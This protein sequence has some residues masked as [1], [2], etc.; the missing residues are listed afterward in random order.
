MDEGKNNW[1]QYG[2]NPHI[3][4]NLLTKEFRC[5]TC[6]QLLGDNAGGAGSHCKG[7]H[8]IRIDGNRIREEPVCETETIQPKV[9]S[10]PATQHQLVPRPQVVRSYE[11]EERRQKL[12]DELQNNPPLEKDDSVK[13][14]E[15]M[16]KKR[17]L[18]NKYQQLEINR[19]PESILRQYRIE[20]G[21]EDDY[22][23]KKKE[24]KRKQEEKEFVERLRRIYLIKMFVS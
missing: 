5:V 8:G 2:E 21:V 16:E 14:Y 1:A 19:V 24:Q 13:L 23:R 4:R 6:N 22:V 20:L 12:I 18:W 3:Q 11:D 9:I 15:D 7:S 17:A 10:Y